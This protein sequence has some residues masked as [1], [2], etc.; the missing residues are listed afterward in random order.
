MSYF[1]PIQKIIILK[2]N[3]FNIN[4]DDKITIKHKDLNMVLFQDHSDISASLT[5]IWT[6][7][8]KKV[9]GINYC[10]CDLVEE[11]EIANC[12]TT[13]SNDSSS[14]YQK[15]CKHRVP[16]ILV[17]RNGKPQS[18]F[19]GVYSESKLLNY[20]LSFTTGSSGESKNS[21]S[22]KNESDEED[23]KNDDIPTIVKS[24]K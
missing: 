20:S 17:Y 3:D 2:T 21:I 13:I 24:D 16:F 12:I 11:S 23:N 19:Q 18:L 4:E 10:V 1:F 15:F 8:S 22:I 6:N 5:P 9:V 14:P 7:L